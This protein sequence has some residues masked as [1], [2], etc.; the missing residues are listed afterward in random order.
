MTGVGFIIIL[1]AVANKF[2][3]TSRPLETNSKP[4]TGATFFLNVCYN[5]NSYFL[6][7]V[8]ISPLTI[9]INVISVIV[10][11]QVPSDVVCPNNQYS[12]LLQ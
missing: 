10:R 9:K 8:V 4:Q 11:E 6:F 3:S 2:L 12:R 1:T 5:K 7:D